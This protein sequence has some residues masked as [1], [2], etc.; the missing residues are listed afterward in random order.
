MDFRNE[1]V[2]I[3]IARKVGTL[4]CYEKP[5]MEDP[6]EFV[7]YKA[8]INISKPLLMGV[9]Q[10]LMVW[11]CGFLLI[12]NLFHYIASNV[13]LLVFSLNLV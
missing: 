7:R 2:I 9:Q 3:V 8:D 5:S 13:G 10:N 4:E 12:M 6:T 1:G 11:V